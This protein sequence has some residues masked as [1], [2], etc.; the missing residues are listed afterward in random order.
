MP[1]V[2]VPPGYIRPD[3]SPGPN[4]P[5]L[6]KSAVVPLND[7]TERRYPTIADY[8][9]YYVAQGLVRDL[10]DL[11]EN[12][13]HLINEIFFQ[14]MATGQLGCLFAAKLAK[15]PRENRWLPI[16]VPHA[17]DQP[18]ELG[19]FLNAQLDTASENHE[20]AVVIFPDTNG[21]DK[22]VALVNAL[23]NDPSERWYRTDDGIDPDPSGNLGLIG[24]RWILGDG[25]CVNYV[26]GF[27]SLDSMPVTRHSPFTAL[28]FRIGSE[29]R[30]PSHRENGLVQVHL[31][32]LDSTF[33]P[34][35]LHDS[36]WEATK[37]HRA[38]HVEPQLAP[39]ARARVT[40][41]VPR[42]LTGALCPA[43][44]VTLEKDDLHG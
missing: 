43:K 33:H 18:R 19:D 10:N 2:N 29:K 27:A 9:D 44:Q 35:S 36:V 22:I 14:W 39:A 16:V 31:A 42:S 8:V 20:A 37:R 4:L 40:F 5:T 38:K 1:G 21:P 41:A 11:I 15:K 13:P 30:T 17:L 24:L 23:C 6:K 34:Q 7:G 25:R 32:D 28:F 12:Y 3:P 26:L